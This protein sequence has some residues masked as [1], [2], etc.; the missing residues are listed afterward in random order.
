MFQ[1]EKDNLQR[2]LME[3]EREIDLL[4]RNSAHHNNNLGYNN[5]NNRNSYDLHKGYKQ[6]NDS[7]FLLLL[8][9]TLFI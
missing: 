6:Y 9:F 8:V 5:Y 1:R 7:F 4:R 3:K 2:L